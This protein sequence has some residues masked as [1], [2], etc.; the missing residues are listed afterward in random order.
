MG[1]SSE[2][3]PDDAPRSRRMF[4]VEVVVVIVI[5]VIVVIG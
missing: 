2:Q 3:L 4:L 1:A 5:V